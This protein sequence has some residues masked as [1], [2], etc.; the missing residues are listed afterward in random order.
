LE[1]RGNGPAYNSWK[2]HGGLDV[3]FELSNMRVDRNLN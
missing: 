1:K 2:G 3:V